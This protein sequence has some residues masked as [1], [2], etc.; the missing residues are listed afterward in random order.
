MAQFEAWIIQNRAIFIGSTSALV[1]LVITG[2]ILGV[3]N[4]TLK[5]PVEQQPSNLENGIPSSNSSNT[6]NKYSVTPTDPSNNSNQNTKES[7]TPLG[8]IISSVVGSIVVCGGIAVM[9]WFFCVR[10]E[11]SSKSEMLTG[12]PNHT[13]GVPNGETGLPVATSRSPDGTSM[14]IVS[15]NIKSLPD[16][17]CG[18]LDSHYADLVLVQQDTIPAPS[19]GSNYALFKDCGSGSS[20][21]SA[22]R[23]TSRDLSIFKEESCWLHNSTGPNNPFMAA[24]LTVSI[25]ELKIA[26]VLLDGG[27]LI[28]QNLLTDGNFNDR[29]AHKL[30][31][32]CALVAG[33]SEMPDVIIGCFCS[34][35]YEDKLLLKASYELEISA[36]IKKYNKARKL[37]GEERTRYLRWQLESFKL[38]L[39]AGYRHIK[40]QQEGDDYLSSQVIE[41]YYDHVFIKE[42][43][44]K[45]ISLTAS[46]S[47]MSFG[48]SSQKPVTLRLSKT[49]GH[50]LTPSTSSI[51]ASDVEVIIE[52]L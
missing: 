50:S 29:L 20:R 25:N 3:Y 22:Y 13:I 7:S 9:A 45:T 34:F 24:S 36:Y 11:T 4:G 14:V 18:F 43:L 32:L 15:A 31:P 52:G 47:K 30:A 5:T 12:L 49:D 33:G 44:L 41:S 26:S 28:D 40:L 42:S 8:V 37:T 39:S 2:A 46:V 6:L 48:L 51:T 10:N 16:D 1:A 23:S 17:P 21:I 35:F 27:A 38:L 19:I